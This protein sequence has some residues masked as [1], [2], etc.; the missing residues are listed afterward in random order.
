MCI[1]TYICTYIHTQAYSYRYVSRRACAVEISSVCPIYVY[2]DECTRA[3]TYIPV[4]GCMNMGWL[5]L[6]GSLK[7]QDKS[8]M[9]S[10]FCR[11]SFLLQGSFA[12]ESYDFKDPTNRSHPIQCNMPCRGSV[13]KCIYVYICIYI[14]LYVCTYM[15]VHQRIYMYIY[16]YNYTYIHTYIHTHLHKYLNTN[17]HILNTYMYA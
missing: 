11:I 2:V 17:I 8:Q 5:W 7:V 9:I 14:H 13:M 16:I 6:V 10:L 4:C 12:K 3:Y 15:I 1:H